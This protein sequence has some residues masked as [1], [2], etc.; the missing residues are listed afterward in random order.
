MGGFSSGVQQGQP[1]NAGNGKGLGGAPT[2]DQPP[3]DPN[4][5]EGLYQ[6]VV[7]RASDQGGADYWKQQFGDTVDDTERQTFINA[8]QPELQQ[9]GAQWGPAQVEGMPTFAG[10]NANGKGGSSVNSYP[11]PQGMQGAS[12]NSATSGQPRMGAPNQYSNTVGQWDNTQIKPTGQGG[13]GKGV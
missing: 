5:V 12:T 10:G 2:P 11:G 7:G 6:N 3:A 4:S 8:A 13:K 1:S 9:K